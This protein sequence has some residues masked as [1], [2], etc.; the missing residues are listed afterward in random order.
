MCSE[1]CETSHRTL[2]RIGQRHMCRASTIPL[3]L[4]S[5]I[6]TNAV[7]LAHSIHD[8]L[9]AGRRPIGI[10]H[11]RAVVACAR[12]RR[13]LGGRLRHVAVLASRGTTVSAVGSV[14]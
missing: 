10:P 12:T 6:D 13:L 2:D 5:P 8:D 4:C 11:A 1:C 14:P 9:G 7:P 3:Q